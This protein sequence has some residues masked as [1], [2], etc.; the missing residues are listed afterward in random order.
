MDV[1]AVPSNIENSY[2][3]FSQIFLIFLF[4]ILFFIE[5]FIFFFPADYSHVCKVAGNY[6]KD[7]TTNAKPFGGPD[8]KMTCDTIINQVLGQNDFSSA[9]DCSQVADDLKN[10][11]N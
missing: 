7:H 3:L 9:F 1:C 5:I 10:N 6:L 11:K 8:T 2:F 4:F